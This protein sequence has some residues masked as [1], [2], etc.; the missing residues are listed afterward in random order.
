MG[1]RIKKHIIIKYRIIY[2]IMSQKYDAQCSVSLE[3][4]HTPT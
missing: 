1:A 2:P 4:Q 3:E